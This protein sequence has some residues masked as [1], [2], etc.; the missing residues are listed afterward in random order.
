MENWLAYMFTGCMSDFGRY[1]DDNDDFLVS[2]VMNYREI[3]SPYINWI[4]DFVLETSLSSTKAISQECLDLKR[5]KY[6]KY[7]IPDKTFDAYST[8]ILKIVHSLSLLLPG[9]QIPWC[10]HA[11]CKHWKK[12]L[13]EWKSQANIKDE[14]NSPTGS[15]NDRGFAVSSGKM[16][17]II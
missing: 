10:G 11:M 6:L 8:Y 12:P 14:G 1:S 17:W 3:N 16:L 2:R 7:L 4:Q 5:L 15:S 13:W 9:L